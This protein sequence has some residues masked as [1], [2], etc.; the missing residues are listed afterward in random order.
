MVGSIRRRK[1]IFFFFFYKKVD[2]S[3]EIAV[4]ELSEQ[5][6]NRKTFQAKLVGAF[7]TIRGRGEN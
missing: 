1:A 3:S 4:K 5:C 7:S 2:T 6:A